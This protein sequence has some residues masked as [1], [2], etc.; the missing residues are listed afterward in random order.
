MILPLNKV[1]QD[2]CSCQCLINAETAEVRT[3][4]NVNVGWTGTRGF[5]SLSFPAQRPIG[6]S[7]AAPPTASL[8]FSQ[9]ALRLCAC[10]CEGEGGSCPASLSGPP[11]IKTS[12]LR[13][14]CVRAYEN[15]NDGGSHWGAFPSLT[16]VGSGVGWL[17]VSL[18]H[19]AESCALASEKQGVESSDLHCA[20][21]WCA[22]LRIA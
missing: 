9:S 4:P 8:I 20:A 12:T 14:F 10:P 7:N 15:A 22:R 2:V 1:S 5:R 6:D 16:G 18:R 21:F 17:F 13:E 11:R 19:G 3:S